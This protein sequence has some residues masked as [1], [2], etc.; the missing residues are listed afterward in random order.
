M[1]LSKRKSGTGKTAVFA[2]VTLQLV[3]PEKDEIQCLI[4]SPTRELAYETSFVYQVLGEFLNVKVSLLIE[5]T[6][7][8]ADIHKLKEGSQILVGSPSRALDLIKRKRISL[9]YLQTFILDEADEIL[10]KGFLDTIKKIIS[11]IPK[12]ITFF[13]LLNL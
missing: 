4:L 10:S 12:N 2:I 9:S 3:D 13:L 11:L 8:N 6:I 1:L 7:V 5:G